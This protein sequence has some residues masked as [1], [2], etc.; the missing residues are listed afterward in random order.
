[1]SHRR[2]MFSCVFGAVALVSGCGGDAAEPRGGVDG[3]VIYGVPLEIGEDAATTGVLGRQGDC[4]VLDPGRSATIVVWPDGTTWDDEGQRVRTSS[5][6][7]I[8]LGDRINVG[9]GFRLLEAIDSDVNEE[10]ALDQL[11]RCVES[12]PGQELFV[13]Q[14]PLD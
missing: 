3:P 11:R 4:L 12:T 7:F 13:I 1:M 2:H 14:Q 5:G 9:G 6:S 10:V 8:E